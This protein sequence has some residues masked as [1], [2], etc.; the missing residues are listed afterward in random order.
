MARIVQRDF[1]I[2]ILRDYSVKV[3]QH[4]VAHLFNASHVYLKDN[5]MHSFG[6]GDY[7]PVSSRKQIFKNKFRTWR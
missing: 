5:M 2:L 1:N 6:V 4:E 3:I 7:W